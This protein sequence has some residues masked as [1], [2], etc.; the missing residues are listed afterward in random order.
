MTTGAL[1]IGAFLSWPIFFAYIGGAR[2]ACAGAGAD[3]DPFGY[4]QRRLGASSRQPDRGDAG[5][6]DHR[7]E[8]RPPLQLGLHGRGPEPAALLRLSVAV[9]LR[10]ADAGDRRQPGADVLRLGRR[11]PRVLSAD[12]LLVPQAVRQCRRAQGVRRQP[13]RRFRLQ[14]R[15]LR[16]LPG[17]RNRLDP[18]DPRTPRRGWPARRSALRECASTR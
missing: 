2:A 18:G 16:D 6:R 17:V 4:A 15:H 12:R 5:R 14:P 8:P 7:V 10:D 11:R 3:L 1:F 13:H 9:Q